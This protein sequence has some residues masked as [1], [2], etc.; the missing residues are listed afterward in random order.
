[1]NSWTSDWSPRRSIERQKACGGG[2]STEEHRGG[3]PKAKRLQRRQKMTGQR[4]GNEKFQECGP[5]SKSR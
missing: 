4:Q 1:M 3:V 5:S 2:V